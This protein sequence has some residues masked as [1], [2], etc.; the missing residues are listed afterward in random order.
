MPML[1][2]LPGCRP[3]RTRKRTKMAQKFEFGLDTFGDVT[4]GPD[5]K[6][7]THAQV[8][9]NVVDEGTSVEFRCLTQRIAAALLDQCLEAAD[10]A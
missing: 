7:L 9:R 4:I 8:I 3:T 10:V 2:R 1:L 5:G 6:P